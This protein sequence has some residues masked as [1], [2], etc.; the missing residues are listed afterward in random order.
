MK[1]VITDFAEAKLKE[2]F[3]YYKREATL[4]IAK[5]IKRKIFNKIKLTIDNPLIGT[6]DNYLKHLSLGH[7]NLIEGNYKIVYR[8]SDN[9]IYITDIFDS[10]QD[11]DKQSIK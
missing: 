9:I 6:E 8:L 3:L 1:I 10:R 4:T 2:I 5:K 11:P 7:R